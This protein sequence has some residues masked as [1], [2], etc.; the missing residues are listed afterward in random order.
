ML[1]NLP[2]KALATALAVI[3]WLHVVTDKVYE[4]ERTFPVSEVITSES[5][6]LA[7]APPDSLKAL[8]SATGKAFLRGGWQEK[9]VSIRIS[10]TR[11]GRRELELTTE[12]VTITDGAGVTLQ[13]VLSP[14]NYRFNLDVLDSVTLPIKSRI[15]V[16]PSA[17][18]VVGPVDS[19]DPAVALAIGPKS[20]IQR[21]MFATTESRIE[22]NISNDFEM[23]VTL[24]APESY[25]VRFLPKQIN[26][27]VNVTAVRQKALSDVSIA[28]LNAPVEAASLRPNKVNLIISGAIDEVQALSAV[29]VS[30]TVDFLQRDLNGF[31]PINVS[32]SPRLTLVSMSDSFTRVSIP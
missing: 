27:R 3:L 20:A 13:S 8:V 23:R 6:A 25:G 17:G 31:A 24:D 21:L 29:D 14:R 1:A 30:V 16:I 22:Q 5:R 15:T 9:G 18:F 10:E 19:L 26:Y 12:N 32:L 4:V 28:L 7:E 11:I 2:L